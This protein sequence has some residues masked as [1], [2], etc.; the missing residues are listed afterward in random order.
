MNAVKK[1]S[2][3]IF[4]ATWM[5]GSGAERGQEARQGGLWRFLVTLGGASRIGG[6]SAQC[7]GGEKRRESSYAT[8]A[9]PRRAAAHDE[10]CAHSTTTTAA[11][12]ASLEAAAVCPAGAAAAA[13]AAASPLC[14]RDFAAVVCPSRCAEIIVA[15]PGFPTKLGS[16]RNPIQR[17]NTRW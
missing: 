11:A 14:C 13:A 8:A 17:P 3:G 4:C 10:S 12:G 5:S 2:F 16:V 15:L 1:G 9:R 7:I 6:A